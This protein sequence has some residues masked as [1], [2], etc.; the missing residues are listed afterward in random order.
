MTNYRNV[1]S[2]LAII[3]EIIFIALFWV[4]NYQPIFA[5]LAY[6]SIGFYLIVH[7][8]YGVLKIKQLK[9]PKEPRYQ[10]KKDG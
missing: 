10:N 2:K 7:I 5:H 6:A 1:L 9:H 3:L 8:T 4:S